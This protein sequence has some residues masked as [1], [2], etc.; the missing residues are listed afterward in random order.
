MDVV[1]VDLPAPVPCPRCDGEMV[2]S[3][4]LNP[5]GEVRVRPRDQ[6]VFDFRESEIGAWTC[7]SCGY[8]ELFAQQPEI[9]RIAALEE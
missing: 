1:H 6:T 9:F 3:V 5:R 2:S 7:G 4:L 8:I